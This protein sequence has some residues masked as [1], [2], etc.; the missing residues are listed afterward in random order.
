MTKDEEMLSLIKS[1]RSI[2]KYQKTPVE[3]D[4]VG[5]ILESGRF[6]PSA[7]NL[8]NWS[9]CVVTKNDIKQKIA[10]GCLKQ[11][12]IADAPALIV[13]I[14]K[15]EKAKMYYGV[16]GERLYSVQNCSAAA[17]NMMLQAEACGLS[18]CWIG[19]FDENM[20]KD[21]LGCDGDA[22]PQII[23]TV[24][25]ADE[26]VPVP[27]RKDLEEVC[28]LEQYGNK[29]KDIEAVMKWYGQK[30]QRTVDNS[31]E[32]LHKTAEKTEKT[33]KDYFSKL[34]DKIKK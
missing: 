13:L 20:L 4:K 7:G 5:L 26:Q 31:K 34:R 15:T 1:R 11:Y 19:A 17:M 6:A 28:D 18:T 24:G 9:F 30:V 29:I 22:R 8:Q 2:R 25:Y 16:R 21:V 32:A 10:E 27:K 12:W 33:Y 14:A 23:L 3:W